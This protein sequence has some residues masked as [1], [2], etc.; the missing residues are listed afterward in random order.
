MKGT[1]FRDPTG[2][3]YRATT[4]GEMKERGVY[5]Y[6]CDSTGCR[7]D[8]REEMKGRGVYRYTLR[9]TAC[10]TATAGKTKKTGIYRCIPGS[11]NSRP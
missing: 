6:F 5:R 1:C 4:T 3:S 9:S 8:T 7:T 2:G 11:P 10:R